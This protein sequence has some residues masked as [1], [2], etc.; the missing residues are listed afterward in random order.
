MGTRSTENVSPFR[1]GVVTLLAEHTLRC[2]CLRF[3]FLL[4]VHAQAVFCTMCARIVVITVWNALGY[5]G[6][7]LGLCSVC[8][9]QPL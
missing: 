2:A 3:V 5:L 9:F 6:H 8:A 4:S 1:C 7:T